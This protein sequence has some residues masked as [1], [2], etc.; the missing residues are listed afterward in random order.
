M[1]R[2]MFALACL[3]VLTGVV[4]MGA[5]RAGTGPVWPPPPAPARI[6]FLRSLTP[7]AVR[8]RPSLFSRLVGALAGGGTEPVMA[9]P[10]GVAVGPD[11]RLYVADSVGG[12][13]HV[14]DVARSGY[15]SIAVDA[16]SLIGIAFAGPVMAVTDSVS[17]RVLGL[18]LKG[19]RLWSLGTRDG[20]ERPTGLVSGGDRFHVVDTMRHR[21]VTVTSDGRVVG[22]FGERGAG[23]GQLN[24]PTNIARAPDGRLFVTDTMN[25]RVQV[26]DP[27]GRALGTFGH[28]GD[29]PGDFDKPKGT[30][31]DRSGHVY[32]VEGLHDV[33]QIFDETG[34]LL[35]AFG[36]SGLGDGELWLPTG[37]AIA[38]NRVYVADS[39]NHRVQMFESLEAG[40]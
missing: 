6:R 5:Q 37:I 7:A 26:F 9:Q 38:D 25:F 29:G 28:V 8:G 19:R 4:P 13:V 31:V 40:R 3:A 10:Y 34:Q 16:Q 22:S 39:A 14:Y 18:D 24:F 11:R 33:V 2:R 35:L 15:T 32:V 36:G 30:A 1:S 23:Q 27:S 12:L 20:F 21:V 17:G